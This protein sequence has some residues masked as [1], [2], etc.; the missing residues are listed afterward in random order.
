MT[1]FSIIYEAQTEDE[2]RDG[3]LRVFNEIVDQVMLAEEFGFDTVW[4]VEHTSLSNYSHMSAPETFLA[5]I[6][7]RTTRI[8]IG[9]GV[10]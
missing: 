2:S 5:Y 3:D 10:V 9:H 4:C 7:G 6:A 8:G 1:K